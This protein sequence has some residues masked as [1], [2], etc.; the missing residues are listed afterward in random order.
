MQ[1]SIFEAFGKA[2]QQQEQDNT[3]KR[4]R[5]EEEQ[6]E[7]TNPVEKNKDIEKKEKL[8]EKKKKK[9]ALEPLRRW[10]CFMNGDASERRRF[11]ATAVCRFRDETLLDMEVTKLAFDRTGR[12]LA[13]AGRGVTVFEYPGLKKRNE[14][15]TVEKISD[16]TWGSDD[17][18]LAA[19]STQRVYL[20]RLKSKET[21][22]WQGSG[23][24]AC[25]DKFVV[26]A[27][28][29]GQVRAWH[30]ETKKQAWQLDPGLTMAKGV[31]A[32]LTAVAAL[33]S[34]LLVAASNTG[35]LLT[36]DTTQRKTKAFGAAPEPAFL[37]ATPISTAL[38]SRGF[39]SKDDTLI[40]L[41][42][43]SLDRVFVSLRSTLH[44]GAVVGIVALFD[45]RLKA[46][47]ALVAAE[48]LPT[49]FLFAPFCST[50]LGDDWGI[51]V[52]CAGRPPRAASSSQ[53]D[54]DTSDSDETRIPVLAVCYLR[55]ETTH[56]PQHDVIMRNVVEST[57]RPVAL[58]KQAVTAVTAHPTT[59]D[60]IWADAGGLHF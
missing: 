46:I 33:D 15:F 48:T 3:K 21:V 5:D 23:S 11:G 32:A 39:S 22:H 47:L 24:V 40:D 49:S 4:T 12:Y 1:T 31:P 30:V 59:G 55:G 37:A 26:V 53:D 54:S 45:C 51:V 9:K 25:V 60:I 57:L 20:A 36:W 18:V 38:K 19:T 16:V 52:A 35:A 43:S 58:R 7:N 8:P 2:Q 56:R 50:T 29:R 14:F 41:R 17:D 44:V 28:T 13:V 10:R 27:S 6:K 34:G 42:P